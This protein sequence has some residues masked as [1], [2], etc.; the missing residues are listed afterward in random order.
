V[1]FRAAAPPA[2]PPPA[3][4]QA[5]IALATS[6][7]VAPHVQAAL[8]RSV[9]AKPVPV[10]MPPRP[11]P[12]P[13]AVRAPV[14]QRMQAVAVVDDGVTRG[15]NRDG[16]TVDTAG[17]TWTAVRYVALARYNYAAAWGAFINLKFTPKAPANAT[18]IALV[19][20]VLTFKNADFY[21]HGDATTEARAVGGTSIDQASNSRSPFYAD[22]PT[23]GNGTLGSS[24][25]QQ[26][27]GEH[28][29]RYTNWWGTLKVKDAWLR[30]TPHLRGINEYSCQLFETTALAVEGTDKGT[31]YG[32]VKW[33][34]RRRDDGS[35][36]LDPLTK[37]SQGS[38][39]D[40]F[41][42]S[43]AQWNQT[44]TSGNLTPP[45]L[46]NAP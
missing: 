26:I 28:G 3:A 39:S 18:K 2:P 24:S 25:S 23:T 32:S 22:N 13:P 46:P 30:D 41:K 29:Y 27:A 40:A 16:E 8:G 9:Q 45:Q 36:E 17:G 15:M 38:V 19:Q 11:L 33:G 5:R 14:V 20:S 7:P 12:A 44:K 21:Y 35:V 37:A 34:W 6:R 10:A 42:V 1:I 31:Y 4:V 43:L